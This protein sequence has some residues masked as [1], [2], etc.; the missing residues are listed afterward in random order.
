MSS[1]YYIII[2]SLFDF[3]IILYNLLATYIVILINKNFITIIFNIKKIIT[4]I[5]FLKIY[6]YYLYIYF[7]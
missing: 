4:K 6:I 5:L 2:F 7:I 1:F 3:N